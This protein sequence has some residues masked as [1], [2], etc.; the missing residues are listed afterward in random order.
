MKHPNPLMLL[1]IAQADA[2]AMATEYLKLPRDSEVMAQAMKF[3]RY[4][5]HPIH[6]LRPGQYTDDTQMSIA[7]AETILTSDTSPKSFAEAFVRCYQRDRREG[8][9]RGFQRVLDEV[10]DGEDFL[11]RIRPDSEK[12]G[13]AMRS[14]P[15]GVIAQPRDVAAIARTQ[16]RLTHDTPDGILSSQIVALL[17]HLALYSDEPMGLDRALAFCISVLPESA[18]QL[19]ALRVPWEGPVVGP[20]VG[21]KTAHA[22]LHLVTRGEPLMGIL[23]QIIEWGGDTDSVAAIAWGIASTRDPGPVPDFLEYGLEPGGRYG[24]MFLKQL[25]EKLM[26]STQ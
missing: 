3:E 26:G 15:L 14:V 17:S 18:D 20:R 25:G 10:K 13:A 2:Y 16:A 1:R 7:V 19:E 12:N 4:G 11:A 22:V 9:A 8:Y 23:R 5:R 24:V 6:H 21:I